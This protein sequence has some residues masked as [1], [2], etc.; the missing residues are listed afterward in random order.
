MPRCKTSPVERFS[1]R[2]II[3]P[4]TGCWLWTGALTKAGY[5]VF[6]KGSRGEG[7]LYAH[8]F[9]F[10]LYCGEIPD[11]LEIDHLCHQRWCVNP[12][13]L[14]A[15][16]RRQNSLRGNHPAA[17]QWRANNMLSYSGDTIV[18]PKHWP[19]KGDRKFVVSREAL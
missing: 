17:V 19:M 3:E 9:S 7:I 12:Y 8:R 5:G 6:G 16:T 18:R 2:V 1:R 15:V 10:A 13:H 14:E 11:G 4:F